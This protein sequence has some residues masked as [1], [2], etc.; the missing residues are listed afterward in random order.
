MAEPAFQAREPKEIRRRLRHE[1]VERRRQTLRGAEN[2]VAHAIADVA[3]W[4]R[5]IDELIERSHGSLPPREAMD[6]LR[7]HRERAIFL[8]VQRD[9]DLAAA[10]A[11]YTKAVETAPTNEQIAEWQAELEAGLEVRR[12]AAESLCDPAFATRIRV[13]RSAL[14][15]P[16]GLQSLQSA[17][18]HVE[19]L[20][21][22]L[23][24]VF[25]EQ[26]TISK[27]WWMPGVTEDE[28]DV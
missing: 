18:G 17:I 7:A 22:N 21:Y 1:G 12:R 11:A 23:R 19:R 25:T 13:I 2:R 5:K 6:D 14:G 26:N 9:A 27:T 16:D 4:D 3:G 24:L 10:Q 28:A 20:A 15:D 8:K